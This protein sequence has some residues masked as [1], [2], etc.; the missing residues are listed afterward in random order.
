MQYGIYVGIIV[1]H[2][3]LNSIAVKFNGFINQ[4]ACKHARSTT[5]Q[6]ILIQSLVFVNMAGIL[7][8]VIVGLAITRP[9]AT[10]S[11][12]VSCVYN[13][14]TIDSVGAQPLVQ[15]CS[16]QSFTMA[17]VS[18]VMATPSFL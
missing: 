4:F 5:K 11:F 2:G 3:I 6:R 9:L 7:F 18:R 16:F 14:V 12:V 8:I 10:G 13:N 1:V 17:L 15:S